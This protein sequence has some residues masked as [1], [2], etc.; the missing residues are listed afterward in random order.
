MCWME[1]EWEWD[2]ICSKGFGDRLRQ[3]GGRGN[4]RG[5]LYLVVQDGKG[6]EQQG[7][8][9]NAG[10]TLEDLDNTIYQQLDTRR[11]RVALFFFA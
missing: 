9:T 4:S 5:V 10:C 11:E 7:D 3:G 6:I 8:M 2:P 1:G